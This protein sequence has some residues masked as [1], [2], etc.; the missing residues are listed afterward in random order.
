LVFDA[1]VDNRGVYL[2]DE[3]DAIGTQRSRENEVGEIRRVLN[4][5]LQFIEKDRSDSIIV[6][7][8]NHREL[9]DRALFRRFDDVLSYDLPGD[10]ERIRMM[11]NCLA[12]FESEGLDW[13]ALSTNSDGLSYADLDRACQDAAKKV[14]L[15]DSLDVVSTE[16]LQSA[17]EDRKQKV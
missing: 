4:S 9:L 5:F 10:E 8:T 17:I 12:R 11:K 2:F 14:V 13:D 1:M 3:F 15:D 16:I 7:A 6:A